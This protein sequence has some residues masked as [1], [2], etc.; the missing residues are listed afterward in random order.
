[1][2]HLQ[3]LRMEQM[4]MTKYTITKRKVRPAWLQV[5]FFVAGMVFMAFDITRMLWD[6][7]NTETREV[8]E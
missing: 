8:E 2:Q 4:R 1:M 6:N 5:G 7:A 3:S